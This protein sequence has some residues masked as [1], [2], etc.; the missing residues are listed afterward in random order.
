MRVTQA[1]VFPR[2]GRMAKFATKFRRSAPPCDQRSSHRLYQRRSRHQKPAQGGAPADLSL[3]PAHSGSERQRC[4]SRLPSSARCLP[5]HRRD[6]PRH[7][8]RLVTP[9][10]LAPSQASQGRLRQP[11]RRIISDGLMAS[12]ASCVVALQ[13]GLTV[14][15]L[16]AGA[17][18]G[19]GKPCSVWAISLPTMAAWSRHNF[20]L[21][22][23]RRG[24]DSAPRL[25]RRGSLNS[26]HCI[27]SSGWN[28]AQGAMTNTSRRRSPPTPGLRQ[29]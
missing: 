12:S 19:V 26:L 10:R 8:P 27:V 29:T 22:I 23:C 25:S 6:A 20:D 15:L 11:N 16:A 2:G 21:L 13:G 4:A 28:S 14:R 18:G 5:G 3:A 9:P 7:H 1:R 17:V 24:S